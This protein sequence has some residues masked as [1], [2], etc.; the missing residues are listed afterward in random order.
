MLAVG[1]DKTVDLVVAE[2]VLPLPVLA[3]RSAAELVTGHLLQ[4]Q[5]ALRSDGGG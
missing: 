2:T 3:E 4:H 5:Q 1:L